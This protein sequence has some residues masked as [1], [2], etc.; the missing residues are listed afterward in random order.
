[1]NTRGIEVILV[2]SKENVGGT[3]EPSLILKLILCSDLM[4][5]SFLLKRIIMY[6]HAMWLEAH[7]KALPLLQ[8]WYRRL[9]KSH[10]IKVGCKLRQL[11]Q[12]KT[13]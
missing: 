6:H 13:Y 4:R 7:R 12:R 9:L 8:T 10:E 2:Q 5:A 3:S 1:M 11:Y